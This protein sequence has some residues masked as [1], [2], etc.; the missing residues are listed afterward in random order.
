MLT[1]DPEEALSTA[2]PA[3]VDLADRLSECAGFQRLADTDNA[4]DALEHIV[5]GPQDDPWSSTAS[6]AEL[7]EILLRANIHN[8]EASPYDASEPNATSSCPDHGGTI[9]ITIRRQI[10]E[11][12]LADQTL[13]DLYLTFDDCISA[14]IH[15]LQQASNDGQPPRLRTVRLVGDVG[16]GSVDSQSAQGVW[17][18]ATIE[19]DWGD[20]GAGGGET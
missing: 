19:A 2:A 8:A 11:A 14:I 9:E 15:D 7:E 17:M 3:K 12:E 1:W 16:F 10:R 5:F 6:I 13:S 4:E 20:R 18:G